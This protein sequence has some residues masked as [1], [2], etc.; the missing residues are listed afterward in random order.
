MVNELQEVV[1]A[2]N[3]ITPLL[4]QLHG[5]PVSFIITD[6]E[7]IVGLLSH[8]KTPQNIHVG[9]RLTGK[10]GLSLSINENRFVSM[11]LPKEF[12]GFSFK[13]VSIPIKDKND[14]IMGAIGI[15]INLDRQ[16]ELAELSHNISDSLDQLAKTINQ[17]T[18]GV[19]DI[20]NYS[21]QNLDK[22]DK[23]KIETQNTDTVL[24]F[25]K[26]VAGQTNLLGLNAAIE[27]AR[28]GEHGRGF[29]V[30]AEEIR[31][32]SKSSADS[33]Q[34]IE[35]TIK[36]I[37]NHIATVSASITKESGILQDQSAA[38]EE[39]NASVEELSS[40]AHLLADNAKKM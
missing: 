32:L 13:G 24:D 19:L 8:P 4:Q 18:A 5:D 22:I 28:A 2:F 37:Q 39:I 12:Y 30:V 31:K 3:K 21:K 16:N 11:V 14:T 34:Q 10:E 15:G 29:S 26:A 40:L 1:E 27:A 33:T 7:K 25:I 35:D 9:D 6:R 20:A 36:A 38:L 23:T 17:V